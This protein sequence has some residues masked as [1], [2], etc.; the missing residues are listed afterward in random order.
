MSEFQDRLIA[1][2]ERPLNDDKSGLCIVDT[3]VRFVPPIA[4]AK[5]LIDQALISR[6]YVQ[7][8][9][10]VRNDLPTSTQFLPPRSSNQFGE[11]TGVRVDLNQGAESGSLLFQTLLEGTELHNFE[12]FTV[13]GSNPDQV[14]EIVARALNLLSD[15]KERKLLLSLF[16]PGV[17]ELG[18]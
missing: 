15:E 18:V 1:E 12:L 2:H 11:L 9:T 10:A 5:S 4:I 7:E 13:A 8:T 3:Y 14:R 17:N 6:T 16:E